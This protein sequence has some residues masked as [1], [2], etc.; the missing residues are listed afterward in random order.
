MT[1]VLSACEG[2]MGPVGE[3]GESLRLEAYDF[4]VVSRDWEPIGEA[5]EV[6]FYQY[7]MDFDIGSHIYKNGDVSVFI[8][9]TDNGNEVQAPLPYSIPHM[10]GS[11]R[12]TEHY[13]FDFD[14]G[15]VSFYADYL[16]G[17]LPPTQDFRVVLTW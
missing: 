6:T 15:T 2:P 1:L 11:V 4:T 14:Q 17:E 8:Y 13:T 3:P 16:R 9:L 12:W 5:G 10:D 7:I